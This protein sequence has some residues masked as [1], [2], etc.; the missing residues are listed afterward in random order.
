[1]SNPTSPELA[2]M[3]RI[4]TEQ[5]AVDF[6][7]MKNRLAVHGVNLRHLDPENKLAQDA[8]RIGALLCSLERRAWETLN[9]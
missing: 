9:Q 8:D 4:R 3:L 6:N 5:A 1:M 2:G 7:D